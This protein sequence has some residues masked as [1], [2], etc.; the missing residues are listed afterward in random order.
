MNEKRYNLG[1]IGFGGMGQYHCASL[2]AFDVRVKPYAVFDTDPQKMKEAEDKGMRTFASAKELVESPDV[3]IV[4]IATCNDSH[5][6]NAIAALKAGKHCICEKPVCLSSSELARVMET[7]KTAE[8]LFTVDQNRRT[9]SDYLLARSVIES[10]KLGKVYR[11]ETRVHGSRGLCEG[12][13]VTKRL[14]GGMMLDWGV[15]LIDQI[16]HMTPQKLTSVYCKM[17]SVK[18][19]E[20]DDNFSLELTFEDGLSVLVEC[21]TNNY[22]QLPRWYVLGE[23]G[24]MKIDD[25]DCNGEIIRGKGDGGWKKLV[26][27]T[28]A[29]PTTTM[30]PRLP[31]TVEKELIKAEPEDSM[32]GLADV[33]A[34]FVK[35]IEG[36]APLAITSA[37]AMRV[38]K[39]M[40]AAFESART[41]DAVKV[42]L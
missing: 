33:H 15:H 27:Y 7:E 26:F 25:W 23:D 36:K 18:Y 19:P 9:N 39:T 5:M 6:E 37:Q 40:E 2:N 31:E 29:G 34:G 4:L 10:G 38:M 32:R 12:W 42:C 11:I 14:G 28:A 20:V 30:A 21:D 8:G 13:R 22:I 1:V 35:A 16:M 41:G 24:T 3:D 17:F